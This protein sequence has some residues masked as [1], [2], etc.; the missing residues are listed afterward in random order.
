MGM[1]ISQYL[2]REVLLVLRVMEEM[3]VLERLVELVARV[4]LERLVMLEDSLV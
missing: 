4:L 3:E 1:L 2:Q